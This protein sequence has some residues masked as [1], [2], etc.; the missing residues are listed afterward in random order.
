MSESAAGGNYNLRYLSEAARRD[1]TPFPAVKSASAQTA[2]A[3]SLRHDT[4][5]TLYIPGA[6][7]LWSDSMMWKQ[8]LPGSGPISSG[9]TSEEGKQWSVEGSHRIFFQDK[10]LE[11]YKWNVQ[12]LPQIAQNLRNQRKQ[13]KQWKIQPGATVRLFDSMT[14]RYLCVIPGEAVVSEAGYFS[15]GETDQSSGRT[16]VGTN[17]NPMSPHCEWTAYYNPSPD[18]GISFYNEENQ[19]TLATTFRSVPD[20]KLSLGNDTALRVLGLKLEASCTTQA[21]Q[22]S[23]KL[24]IVESPTLGQAPKSKA[25]GANREPTIASVSYWRRGLHYFEARNRLGRF[26]KYHSHLQE[27]ALGTL[28]DAIEGETRSLDPAKPDVAICILYL[29]V[30]V[31]NVMAC[32]RFP[33]ATAKAFRTAVPKHFQFRGLFVGCHILSHYM[34]GIKMLHSSRAAGIVSLYCLTE[35]V[36]PRI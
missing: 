33:D 14:T 17:P 35:F 32:R 28:I 30:W 25:S 20:S 13:R 7:F 22:T 29:A 24:S 19:C 10:Y 9:L 6:G 34:F 16:R 31:L 1:I 8:S 36:V 15:K 23:S 4:Q 2:S 11:R 5:Y 27:E 3:F 26:R 18:D 21:S 12:E